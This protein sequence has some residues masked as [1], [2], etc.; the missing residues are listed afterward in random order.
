MLDFFS[1][2]AI[3]IVLAIVIVIWAGYGL[4]MFTIEKKLSLLEKKV[5]E[6]N[7]DVK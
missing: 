1:N 7:L 3:F 2:N 5:V 4:Y 6:N